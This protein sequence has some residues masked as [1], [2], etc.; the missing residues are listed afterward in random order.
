MAVALFVLLGPPSGRPTSAGASPAASPTS[1]PIVVTTNDRTI[2]G[3]TIITSASTGDG[4]QALGTAAKPIR[5]LTIRNCTIRG[6]ATA[7]DVRYVANLTIENCTITDAAY[8]GILVFSG[9]GGTIS[10]N[11]IERIGVG[12]DTSG[13]DANNVYGIA[14]TR[15]A[16][17]DF[18]AEPRT[19]DFVVDGNDIED[20]PLWHGLDTHAGINI[21][22]SN[23]I[24]ARCARPIFITSDSLGNHPEDITVTG[25]RL[26]S[27]V[28][29]PGG[30]NV[31]A[32]TLVNLQAGTI[33]NNT[34]SSTYG[35]PFVYDYLGLDPAGSTNVAVSGQTV[36]P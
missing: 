4:I 9:I 8:A 17:T 11:R 13:P 6:F 36:I 28:Q 32:I 18:E 30:T 33:T 27:A 29:V 19:S 23:N 15:V 5:N 2:D 31:A 25:N 24:I 12:I 34:I 14:L 16:T 1:G 35:T 21:T 7:I 10:G 3:V 26:E 22:F 20:V